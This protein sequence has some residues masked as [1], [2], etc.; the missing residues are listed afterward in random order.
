MPTIQ[1]FFDR[2]HERLF[3][4]EA[5]LTKM[6]AELDTARTEA[7]ESLKAKRDE[8]TASRE[9][10]RQEMSNAVNRMQARVQAKKQETAATIEEWKHKREVDKLEDRALEAEAYAEAAL[11]VLE[12]AQEEAWA[13]SLEALEARREAEDAKQEAGATA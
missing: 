6:R 13:A 9:S 10:R 7:M 5:S 12:L 8:A 1:E 2:E 11:A 4:I 3:R